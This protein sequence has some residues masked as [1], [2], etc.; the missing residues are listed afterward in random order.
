MNLITFKYLGILS[1]FD[2]MRMSK[3]KKKVLN[4][5]TDLLQ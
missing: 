5:L 4:N 3:I 2:C 1:K